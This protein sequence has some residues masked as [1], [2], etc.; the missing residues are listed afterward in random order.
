MLVKF[1]A[2]GRGRDDGPKGPHVSFKPGWLRAADME[3]GKF[4][5]PKLHSSRCCW[6]SLAT[7]EVVVMVKLV[8]LSAWAYSLGALTG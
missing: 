6:A 3:A 5:G 8:H 7:L 4:N 2:S 1:F